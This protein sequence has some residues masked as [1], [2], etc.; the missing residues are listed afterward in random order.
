[1]A[2]GTGEAQKLAPLHIGRG[3]LRLAKVLGGSLDFADIERG[4]PNRGL[5]PVRALG[6]WSTRL[7]FR[8]GR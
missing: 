2:R 1:M 7:G 4:S 6:Q 8:G 3:E 5:G